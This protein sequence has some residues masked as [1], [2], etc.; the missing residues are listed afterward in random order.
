[1]ETTIIVGIALAM[2]IIA[3]VIVIGSILG[4]RN[5]RD[6]WRDEVEGLK[7]EIEAQW[8]QRVSI[9]ALFNLAP[10]RDLAHEIEQ[11]IEAEKKEREFVEIMLQRVAGIFN[12]RPNPDL[13]LEIEEALSQK[14]VDREHTLL[15]LQDAEAEELR[16]FRAWKDAEKGCVLK[17]Q[18]INDLVRRLDNAVEGLNEWATVAMKHQLMAEYWEI[19]HD[20]RTNE[21]H[22]FMDRVNERDMELAQLH[23]EL[24]SE[25]A[26]ANL[27]AKCIAAASLGSQ[28][29]DGIWTLIFNLQGV[30]CAPLTEKESD[31]IMGVA[32]NLNAW[33]R[34]TE[35]CL[36]HA[37]VRMSEIRDWEEG[38][39]IPF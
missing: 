15:A 37:K 1:M 17:Q 33:V 21:L 39:G 34:P 35:A 38:K 13:D 9:A 29:M 10:E 5:E 18:I 12:L 4:L 16:Y 32:K 27:Y 28:A 36:R 3:I 2:G 30:R 6:W 24:E 31:L 7:E 22:I 11:Q 19:A 20:I 26:M 8:Q 25:E 14:D 23:D